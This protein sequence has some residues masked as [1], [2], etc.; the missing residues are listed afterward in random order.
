MKQSREIASSVNASDYAEW[1]ELH[2]Q[3]GIQ[4]PSNLLTWK[5][6]CEIESTNVL[7]VPFPNLV[8]G[9]ITDRSRRLSDVVLLLSLA[10]MASVTLY[11]SLQFSQARE[12]Q[13]TLERW[14][15]GGK[16]AVLISYFFLLVSIIQFFEVLDAVT[17]VRLPFAHQGGFFGAQN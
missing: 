17:I 7:C 2:Y 4:S 16:F 13:A 8:F 9:G 15:K 1:V 11:V 10:L 6:F 5:G 12:D 3:D 14:W